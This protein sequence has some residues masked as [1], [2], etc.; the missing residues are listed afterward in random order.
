MSWWTGVFAIGW[1]MVA[2]SA[3]AA[4]RTWNK[5]ADTG[6]TT[7]NLSD[8]AHWTGGLPTNGDDAFLIW[9]RGG[10]GGPG[11]QLV[12][13]AAAN[14]F[15]ANS[16]S[17]TN[18]NTSD[19][20]SVTA[21]ISGQTFLTNGVGALNFAG[22]TGPSDISFTF[23]GNVTAKTI[24]ISG[25][26]GTGRAA[27][28][29]AGVT[30]ADSLVFNGGAG[31]NIVLLSGA[32]TLTDA[33]VLTN[34]NATSVGTLSGNATVGRL[35]IN[36]AAV[37]RWVIT[38]STTTITGTGGASLLGGFTLANN[39]TLTIGSGATATFSNVFPLLQGTVNINGGTLNSL[40]TWTNTAALNLA[41]GWLGGAHFFNAAQFSGH[42]TVTP[43]VV[44]SGTLTI[45]PAGLTFLGMVTNT[46]TIAVSG[47]NARFAHSLHNSGTLRLNP[48][49]VTFDG[50]LSVAP[51]GVITSTPG[52][53][54]R[55]RGSFLNQSTQN[56]A[57][58]L[59]NATVVF[60][61]GGPT[62]IFTV[63]G[64]DLGLTLD[65]FTNNFALG[66]LQIGD[67]TNAV[68]SLSGPA[69]RALYVNSLTLQSG[70][71]LRLNGL[72][73]YTTSPATLDG[74]VITD[75]GMI[76]LIPEPSSWTLVGCG[77]ALLFMVTR[78][79]R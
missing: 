17:I 70:S 47:A 11:M 38:N 72:T 14:V 43:S 29:L 50:T 10:A 3:L 40:L 77:L 51:S 30:A 33:L 69:G 37:T 61:G 27:F 56:T 18:A 25:G 49:T 22:T 2:G 21:V 53:Q 63:A 4:N 23:N 57:F 60:D 12:T 45:S 16:L 20:G 15:I 42:G 8:A 74:T 67:G 39:A 28:T 35:I 48:G 62:Q 52:S 46:G 71:L 9:N 78:R 36:N 32:L 41:N 79:R 59:L 73:I 66:A 65:G 6:D 24:R 54:L 7:R 13:N 19:K 55:L 44:N 1:L 75:G 34:I 58:D 26:G 76:L 31:S 64:L 68:V 5:N